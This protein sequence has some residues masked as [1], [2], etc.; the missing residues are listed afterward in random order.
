MGY[1]D[2]L[3][4][5]FIAVMIGD[6][7]WLNEISV[8][9]NSSPH[10]YAGK[11]LCWPSRDPSIRPY[12]VFWSAILVIPRTGPIKVRKTV[13]MWL[14]PIVCGMKKVGTK[15]VYIYVYNFHEFC[16]QIDAI[17]FQ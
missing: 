11:V 1:F 3:T 4:I 14:M 10:F 15:V 12:S 7:N 17:N 13:I 8:W 6:W 5:Y 9:I 16:K 2:Y